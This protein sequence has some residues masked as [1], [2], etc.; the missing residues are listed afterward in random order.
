[1]SGGP[2]E[3]TYHAFSLGI[4]PQQIAPVVQ[5]TRESKP[6]QSTEKA[7]RSLLP[8]GSVGAPQMWPVRVVG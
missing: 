4:V 2:L 6:P 7:Q 5:T 3:A 8:T 1:M